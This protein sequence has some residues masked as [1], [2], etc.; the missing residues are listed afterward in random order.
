MFE[1]DTSVKGSLPG[2]PTE[3]GFYAL[4]RNQIITE[5]G[6]ELLKQHTHHAVP[7]QLSIV[8][9]AQSLTYV[10]KIFRE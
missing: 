9:V 5:S 6:N 4:I 3:T 10:P 8:L 2:K 1:L 7:N